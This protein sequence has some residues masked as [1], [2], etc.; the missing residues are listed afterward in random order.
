MT[1]RG[2]I[3]KASLLSFLDGLVRGTPGPGNGE[4]RKA[5]CPFP[6][7]R[8]RVH[9]L[10]VGAV[11]LDWAVP[12]RREDN[13]AAAGKAAAADCSGRPGHYFG[14]LLSLPEP[15]ERTHWRCRLVPPRTAGWGPTV[16]VI[17]EGG[18]F[19]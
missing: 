5:L 4:L 13:A 11:A 2:L 7:A 8:T 19:P 9:C 6:A 15:P 14:P 12:T 3:I 1:S 18:R 17:V 16:C 10:R